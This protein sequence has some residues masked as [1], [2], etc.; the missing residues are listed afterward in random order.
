MAVQILLSGLI[1]FC[2]TL[3]LTPLVRGVARRVGAVAAPTSDRWHKKPTALFGGIGIYFGFLVGILCLGAWLAGHEGLDVPDQFGRLGVGIIG[4]ATLMFLVGLADDVFK[5]RPYSKLV[6]Q[7][8]AAAVLVSCQVVYP[9]TPW[10][11]FNIVF[12][13]FWFIA[14]TNALNLL[15]NMDG[16][17]SG[18]AALAA[19]FLAVTFALAGRWVLASVCAAFSGSML[20]FLRYNFHPAS[21]FMG[22]SG[23]LFVGALLAGLG[24][25]YPSTASG[26]IVSVLFVPSFIVII[27]LLDTTLVTVMRVMAGRPISVG[28]RDHT[29]HR[30]VAMGLTERQVALV[31]YGFAGAGGLVA[32]LLPHAKI[33]GWLGAL[34]LVVLAVL[35]AYLGRMHSY[36]PAQ[37]PS[38]R[39]LT[40]LVSDLLYK[41]RALEVLLDLVLFAFAYSGAYLLRYDADLPMTQAA[42]L[43]RTLAVALA[44]KSVSFGALGVYRGGWQRMTL[45]DLHRIVRAVALGTLLTI[46]ALVFFYRED[47]FARS[48]FVLDAMLT[49]LLTSATRV[50]FR[51]L[52]RIHRALKPAAA[53]AVIYG[54]GLAGEAAVRELLLNPHA[55]LEPIGF[56]DDDPNKQGMRIHGLRVFGDARDLERVLARH[57]VRTLVVSTRKVQRDR[58]SEILAACRRLGVDL[59]EFEMAFRPV[60]E[61][62]CQGAVPHRPASLTPSKQ[63]AFQ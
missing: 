8:V 7:G 5:L 56:M 35:A 49:L 53:R 52:D 54:A 47:E 31:L 22:D 6:F 60:D 62:M 25:A 30:L 20:G 37:V 4:S 3:A 41:R 11:P 48:I 42:V 40:V 29:S 27:P 36:S 38:S 14:L 50:S 63:P 24:A 1:A 12:T 26:S 28:G 33:A 59:L 17:A 57:E 58:L 21:I 18:V 39:R 19:G 16:V 55:G 10:S 9:L 32:L 46:A 34:L 15:D 45:A 51:S 13:I 43:E 2:A 44:V 61:S 23:S